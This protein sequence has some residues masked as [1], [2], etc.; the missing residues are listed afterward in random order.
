MFLK[1]IVSSSDYR[2]I[3]SNDKMIIICWKRKDVKG[4]GHDLV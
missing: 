2:Y 4:L 1:I 3:V